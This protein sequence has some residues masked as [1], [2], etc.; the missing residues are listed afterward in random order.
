MAQFAIV[1]PLVK[2]CRLGSSS[3]G[4][5]SGGDIGAGG[6]STAVGGGGRTF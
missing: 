4:D 5:G 2:P 6:G 3:L 1:A